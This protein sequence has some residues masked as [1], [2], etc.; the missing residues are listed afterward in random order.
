MWLFFLFVAVPIVEIGLFIQVGG[1]LGLWPTLAIVVLTALVGTALMRAQGMAALQKLQTSIESGGNPADPIANGAFI[2]I[3]GLLLLTPGFF[4]DT[5]GLL[6]LVPR[7][8]QALIRAITA[9]IKARATVYTSSGF[10]SQTQY[11]SDTVLEGDFEVV[12][13]NVNGKP[14]NSGWT[15]P[16]E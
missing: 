12:E 13:D 8:R 15:R 2:L 11:A 1:F 4:T 5:L 16:E 7:V 10:Q 3:A 14:G 6:L 9:Q